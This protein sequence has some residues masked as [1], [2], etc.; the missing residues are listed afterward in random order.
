MD[1]APTSPEELRLMISREIK[2]HGDLL[3]TA[4]WVP[5]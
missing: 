5:Q 2:L 3:K 4:G 1:V